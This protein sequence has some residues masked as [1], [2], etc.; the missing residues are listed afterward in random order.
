MSGWNVEPGWT[1]KI[2][3]EMAGEEWEIDRDMDAAEFIEQIKRRARGLG[4]SRFRLFVDDREIHESDG[5]EA[6]QEAMKNATRIK[7]VKF[8]QAGK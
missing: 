4:W 6:L 5:I 7:I 3:V 1:T 8:D 2:K